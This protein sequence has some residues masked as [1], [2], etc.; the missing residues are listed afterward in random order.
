MS[1]QDVY[2][3]S[4]L[5]LAGAMLAGCGGGAGETSPAPATSAA[6]P[7]AAERSARTL[8]IPG[9][10]PA[11][12]PGSSTASGTTLK[13]EVPAAWEVETP[14]S[15][16]RLAQYRAP[17]TAGDGECIV[18][19]FGPGQGG[20]P[21]SNAVRW[22]RQFAQPDGSSP[23]DA[24]VVTELDGAK[25][26]VRLVEVTG[27]YDGGMTMTDA[28]AEEQSGYMLLGG[29]ADGPDA[30][31]FFKFTGPEKTV[32]A[33]REAFETMMRSIHPAEP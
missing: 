20:D 27:T 10:E 1:I 11:P 12:D 18:F 7:A 22:A 9:S 31:W 5:A 30:P 4:I 8:S 17:G 25:V 21:A 16:M 29:I 24:M 13:W 15:T 28:P 26:P 19:Y 2:R 3:I 33:E 23:V 14:A 6:P 32:R